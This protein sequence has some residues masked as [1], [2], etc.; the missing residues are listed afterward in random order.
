MRRAPVRGAGRSQ[1]RGDDR[2]RSHGE[3]QAHPG[4][5]PGA[6][7]RRGRSGGPFRDRY[8]IAPGQGGTLR[9]FGNF[10]T[11]EYRDGA[12]RLIDQRRLP[13]EEVYVECR[14]EEEVAE[15]IRSMA[16]RGAPA[17]GVAAAYGM[18]IAARRAAEGSPGGQREGLER[19]GAP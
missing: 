4:P 6:T 13:T 11:M 16:V 3:A 5:G 8:P 10:R 15:A 14:T 7:G 9:E 2:L 19:A 12:L 18:A 1:E 17:I